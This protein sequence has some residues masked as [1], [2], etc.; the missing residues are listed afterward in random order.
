MANLQSIK[1]KGEKNTMVK[2]EY[3][4]KAIEEEQKCKDYPKYYMARALTWVKTYTQ[5]VTEIG[6]ISKTLDGWSKDVRK[7]ATEQTDISIERILEDM[8][9]LDG[10]I[11]TYIKLT[12]GFHVLSQDFEKYAIIDEPWEYIVQQNPEIVETTKELVDW[13][14]EHEREVAESKGIIIDTIENI[15][16]GV[17]G[18]QLKA[19]KP[20]LKDRKKII[21]KIDKSDKPITEITQYCKKLLKHNEE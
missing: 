18:V 10:E 21:E 20:V 3:I 7:F 9:R 14:S 8:D 11:P 19:K 4:I 17:R 1:K 5:T 13:S 12:D 16:K 2:Y 6:T 15:D